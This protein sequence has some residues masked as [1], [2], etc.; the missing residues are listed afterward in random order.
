[1]LKT[2]EIATRVVKKLQEAGFIAYF[3]GGWVRDHLMQ[4]PSDDIDI[5]TDASVD[6]IKEL[7]A[8]TI[9]VGVAFGIV[10][11]VEE[12]EHFEVAT[13]RKDRGYFDGRR[14]SGIDPA[15]PEEDAQ[16]RDFTINGMFYDPVSEELFDFVGGKEDIDKQVIR[17][18]GDP[19]ERFAEDRLRMMR[20]VRYST[21][22]GFPIEEKTVEAIRAHAPELLPSVAMERVWQEFK[23]MSEFA[24][25][26]TG[27]ILLHD[28]RLLPTIFPDLKEISLEEIQLRVECIERF[29]KDAP[30]FAELLE[31][32]PDHDLDQVSQLAEMLKLSNK[33]KA[34]VQ[35]YYHAQTLCNM[36]ADWLEKLEKIEWAQFYAEDHS[37]IGLEMVSVRQKNPAQFLKEHRERQTMLESH[38]ERI[39]AK[40]PYL[41][42]EHLIKERVQ[43]G[44]KMG[45][46]LTEG[47]RIA[48]NEEITDPNELIKRLK[49]TSLWT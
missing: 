13:F 2:K 34:F 45:E 25:F 33:E 20:A 4:H 14:P 42:A 30:T 36:P 9:P 12:G 49:Q 11:V 7:F 46:L 26:D 1:M 35:F 43:P 28:L 48:V 44:E 29:P 38:I 16:R 40:R 10:I 32:F 41:Q 15:I 18:I 21:R 6:Q 3:A 8:K 19:H 23:K 37:K 22:F 5:A 47:M 39:R 27:L 31:L 17:A 24:H